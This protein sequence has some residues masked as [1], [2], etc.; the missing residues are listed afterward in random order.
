M[1]GLLKKTEKNLMENLKNLKK[2]LRKIEKRI[3][4]LVEN[5]PNYSEFSRITLGNK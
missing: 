2:L 5:L 4:F 3:N 1:I